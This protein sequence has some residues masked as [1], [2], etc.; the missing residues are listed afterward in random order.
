MGI[1]YLAGSFFGQRDYAEILSIVNMVYVLGAALGPF[2]SGKMYDITGG[3]VLIWKIEL[4][5]FALSVIV[6]L[7][8]EK[9]SGKAISKRVEI[10]KSR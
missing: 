7:C 4:V 5:L 6:L 10:E 1:P 8:F 3:Y 9:L 2:I